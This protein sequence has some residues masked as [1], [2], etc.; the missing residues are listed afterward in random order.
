MSL[1]PILVEWD[2][3]VFVPRARFKRRCDEELTVHEIYRM[4][5]SEARSRQSHNHYFAC[6]HDAWLNLPE[7]QADR[8][9]SEE[10]LRKWALVK[11]GYRDERSVVCASKAEAQQVAAFIR[12]MDD[13]AVVVVRDAVVI[14]YTAKSQSVRAMGKKEFG[15]S[16]KAVLDVL[17]Q[18]LGTTADNLGKAA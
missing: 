16:K 5:I 11:A 4:E 14:A 12:P 15:E 17:A 1:P 6:I 13:H 10:H 7:D 8:F 2:G 18:L 3:D 9:P